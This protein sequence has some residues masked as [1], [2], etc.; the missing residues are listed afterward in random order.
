MSESTQ[1]DEYTTPDALA[2]RHPDLFTLA[3]LRWALRFRDENGLAEHVTRLGR[4][5]YIHVPGFTGWFQARGLE[6]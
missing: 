5:L 4:R 3:Q 2:R 6:G 1:L